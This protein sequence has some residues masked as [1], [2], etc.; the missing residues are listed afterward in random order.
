MTAQ[1]F[2]DAPDQAVPT[3]MGAEQYLDAPDPSEGTPF[4]ASLVKEG[5]ADAPAPQAGP[6]VERAAVEDYLDAPV[7]NVAEFL[8]GAG[9]DANPR[10]VVKVL[11]EYDADPTK[12]LTPD[13]YAA[14]E[15]AISMLP[16]GERLRRRWEG[17]VAA[18]KGLVEAAKELN[19]E[20]PS[21]PKLAVDAVAR[22]AGTSGNGAIASLQNTAVNMPGAVA[23]AIAGAGVQG[24][25]Y[26]KD[27]NDVELVQPADSTRFSNEYR[28]GKEYERYIMS[29]GIAQQRMEIAQ[30]TK[31]PG[32]ETALGMAFDPMNAVQFGVGFRGGSLTGQAAKRTV[33]AGARVV[34]VP[35]RFA[36]NTIEA[37]QNALGAKLAAAGMTPELAQNI[38]WLGGLAATGAA[39]YGLAG[40]ENNDAALAAS[41]LLGLPAAASSTKWVARFLENSA[42]TTRRIA[43]ESLSATGMNIRDTAKILAKD[44]EIPAAYRSRLLAGRPVDSPF[45]RIA[46]DSGLPTAARR[47]AMTVDKSGIPRLVENVAGA[48]GA[49]TDGAVLGAA[50][51]SGKSDQD[52]GGA[53]ATGAAFGLGGRLAHKLS[54]AEV[55][56]LQNGDIARM[57]A[58]VAAD[59]GNYKNLNLLSHGELADVAA[60]QGVFGRN[61]K[62]TPLRENEFSARMAD[63]DAP[64]TGRAVH[65]SEP[66][67]ARDGEVILNV[68]RL[69]GQAA[70][71]GL[72]EFAHALQKSNVLDGAQREEIR[73]WIDDS[74]SPEEVQKARWEYA[75]RLAGSDKATDVAR[76]MAYLDAG[77]ANAGRMP[78]DWIRDELW[79]ET[80][81]TSRNAIDFWGSRGRPQMLRGMGRSLAALGVPVDPAT[82]RVVIES[83]VLGKLKAQWKGTALERRLNDYVRTYAQWI[84]GVKPE[85][86]GARVFSDGVPKENRF[87]GLHEVK[88]GVRENQFLRSV[89]GRVSI[90]P[91]AEIDA[92]FESRRKTF[93]NMRRTSRPAKNDREWGTHRSPDGG[94]RVGG[95]VMPDRFH[96]QP[97]IGP[98]MKAAEAELAAAQTSGKSARVV[99]HKIG[100]KTAKG[101]RVKDLGN[102]RADVMEVLPFWRSL[103]QKDNALVH[104]VDMEQLRR[105]AIKRINRGDLPEFSN[106]LVQLERDFKQY[107]QN[108]AQGLPGENGIGTTKRNAINELLGIGTNANRRANPLTLAIGG[109][110]AKSA[111]KTL[112]L[113][114]IEIVR[115]G[116]DGMAFD[117]H[118]ANQ[119]M[120]ASPGRDAS[121]M[122]DDKTELGPR[123]EEFSG[124]PNDAF[125]H[126]MRVKTGY[127]PAALSHPDLGDVDVVWGNADGSKSSAYGLA[128]IAKYHPEMLK[129][130][131]DLFDSF[132]IVKVNE[133][134][135]QLHLGSY[136]AVVRRNWK[137][138]DKNWLLT[139]FD[140]EKAT[141]P[142]RR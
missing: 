107:L 75:S 94:T 87:V 17:G 140:K 111:I 83:P 142:E 108:H 121:M 106:D 11:E 84:D 123:Y 118:K 80:F 100:S 110:R 76:T 134:T 32:V 103:S 109:S 124:K 49:A 47:L 128:K 120:T 112:R 29:K 30:N 133:N 71:V 141:H 57:Y 26:A 126:L 15:K 93:E 12:V 125:D 73:S 45:R 98:G 28:T 55:K 116:N 7:E 10:D 78:G 3:G 77:D 86:G 25:D 117:Y 54:G 69:R 20:L 34:E 62:M 67:G 37:T 31:L 65:I 42:G 102:L 44:T 81:A 138:E 41:A 43:D 79:A 50:F 51:A 68:D 90:K 104:V 39:A 61:V 33:G 99:Y 27:L 56:E 2:L 131:P 59:G 88:P 63:L 92:D 1:D 35:S 132:K 74:F 97:N 115:P 40:E 72:H 66:N 4:H 91:Q 13:E 19:V 60:A 85:E 96:L 95:S 52:M 53:I 9:K 36:A 129:I 113:D 105:N 119:N 122:P 82:G 89:D 22:I 5:L 137:G 130:L 64:D 18:L 135:A 21:V 127:V 136:V 70:H 24:V 58:E 139:S 16:V 101:Y 38:K 114:R 6:T 46:M 14:K 23:N 48:A 8:K